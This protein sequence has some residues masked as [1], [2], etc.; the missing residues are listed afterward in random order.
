MPRYTITDI[1]GTKY[2]YD[3][4]RGEMVVKLLTTDIGFLD[5]LESLLNKNFFQAGFENDFSKPTTL[6]GDKDKN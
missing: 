5:H 1:E 3:K 6:N 4:K 2:L